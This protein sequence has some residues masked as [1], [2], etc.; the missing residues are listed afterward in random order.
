M[1]LRE[2]AMV[3]ALGLAAGITAALGLSRLISQFLF[4]LRPNDPATILTAAAA[5]SLVA[6]LAAFL[7]ARRASRLDPM[8]SLRRE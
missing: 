2:S 4:G 7:P 3:V 5:L 1:V 8:N 6:L